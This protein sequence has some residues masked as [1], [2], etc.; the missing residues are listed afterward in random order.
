MP[1]NNIKIL[2]Y[3][4]GGA[5]KAYAALDY[6][7]IYEDDPDIVGTIKRVAIQMRTYNPSIIA[8]YMISPRRGLKKDFMEARKKDSIESHAIFRDILEREGI[9]LPI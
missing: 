9:K 7:A 8:V 4:I 2:L 5:S 1:N 6:Y 3:G